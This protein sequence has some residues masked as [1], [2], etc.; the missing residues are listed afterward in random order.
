[1]SKIYLRNKETGKLEAMEPVD[2]RESLAS[3]G[4]ELPQPEDKPKQRKA[5]V[6]RR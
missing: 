4:Y 6:K 3:G 1:M 2:A 5:P